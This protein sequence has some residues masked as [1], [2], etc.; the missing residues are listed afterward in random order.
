MRFA[1]A[2]SLSADSPEAARE[3]TE[4]VRSTLGG[5]CP[6]LSL[7][8]VSRHHLTSLERTAASV[9]ERLGGGILLGATGDGIIE[10]S[11]EHEDRPA[12]ALW[13]AA[14]PGT[15]IVA[16][17]ATIDQT[18]DGSAFLGV[19]PAPSGHSTML[20]MGDPFSFD[21]GSFLERIAEDSP[22]CQVLGGMASGARTPGENRVIV[23][24]R[25]HAEGAA[26]VVLSGA[27]RVRPLVS[28]GCRPFGKPLVVTKADGHLVLELG[29]RPVMERFS[30][31]IL[32]LCPSDRALLSRGLHLGIAVD[33][34]KLEHRRG[35]FLVRNVV[36]YAPE[37]SAIVVTERV[38]SGM[39]VQFHLRDASTASEDLGLLL[40]ESRVAGARPLGALLYSCNGRGSHLF[41][42]PNHDAEAIRARFGDLP[43]AG[44][45]AAGEIGPVGGRSFIHGF[46]A[47]IAF[48]EET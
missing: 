10:G 23:D 5:A 35:D 37:R 44:F 42:R 29:G 3:A 2:A 15:R 22:D 46:T 39:T 34:R 11:S 41:S 7:L 36:G 16:S 13:A 45:F 30:E 18:P 19:P 25:V 20:L 24:G 47:S 48:F 32:D 6:D 38:R 1:S 4:D 26:A 33:A 17:H 12:L 28:Q 9:A 43:L 27:V 40:E 14:L 21:T 31:Q 8:F